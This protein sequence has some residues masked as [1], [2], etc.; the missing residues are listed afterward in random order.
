M[1]QKN[2][3]IKISSSLLAYGAAGAVI[4]GAVF[5]AVNGMRSSQGMWRTFDDVQTARTVAVVNE[6]RAGQFPVR[7]LSDFGNGGGYLLLNF[8]SPVVYYLSSSLVLLGTQPLNAVKLTFQLA[9][10][11]AGFG[12]FLAL[13][14]LFPKSI[15]ISVVGSLLFIGS[16]YFNFDAYIRG[17]LP[18]LFGFSLIPWVFLTGRLLIKKTALLTPLSLFSFFLAGLISTHSITAFIAI[19]FIYVWLLFEIWSTPTFWQKFWRLFLAGSLGI[20]LSAFYLVPMM[21]EKEF[22]QYSQMEHVVNGYK[23]AFI[24]LPEMIGLRKNLDPTIVPVTLGSWLSLALVV[25]LCGLGILAWTKIVKLDRSAKNLWL[26]LSLSLIALF[27]IQNKISWQI[28]EFSSFL[29][30]TQF[31]YRYLTITTFL[32]VVAVCFGLVQIKNGWLAGLVGVGLVILTWNANKTFMTPA[33]YY[34]AAEFKAEDP[35]STTT[36][37]HE[38]MSSWTEDCLVKGN[39]IALA[40]GSGQLAISKTELLNQ[41]NFNLVTNGQPGRLILKRYYFPGWKVTSNGTELEIFPEGKN[42]LIGADLTSKDINLSVSFQDTQIRTLANRLSLG[43]LIGLLALPLIDSLSFWIS[44][45][46]KSRN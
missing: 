9:Y 22:I 13:K 28:W 27:I 16:S 23:S 11:V 43:S 41:Q 14:N 25:S 45:K 6:L 8:Y 44:F 38:F 40:T 42:G 30:L 19:P 29:Q 7:L 2:L 17:A 10:A 33:G 20:S 4:L 12:M 36:W 24:T 26:Y 35:C 32:A 5:L 34:F 37:E 21:I 15:L 1:L 46:R 18:E 31:P 3:L 39:S